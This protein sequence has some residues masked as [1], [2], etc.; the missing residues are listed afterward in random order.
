MILIKIFVINA[1]SSSLKYQLF[2]MPSEKVLAKGVVERIGESDNVFK[3]QGNKTEAVETTNNVEN[4][5][6]A[7]EL[8]IN[9]LLKSKIIGNIDEIKGIGHRIVHGGQHFSGATLI[10]DDVIKKIESLTDLAPI[11]NSANLLGVLCCKKVFGKRV[12]QVAVFDTSFYSDMPEKAYIYG[13][14]YEYYGKYGVRKYGFHGTSHRYVSQKYCEFMQKNIKSAKIISCHLGN[15]SSITAINGG[16]AID[17]T[18]GFTPL[19]GLIMGTRSGSIDPSIINFIAEKESLSFSEINNLLNKKS[20]FLGIAGENDNRIITKKMLN[21]NKNARLAYEI[22]NYQIVK[23][24]GSYIAVMNG[25][26]GIIFTGGIGENDALRRKTVCES[27]LF[28][29]V[30]I[31]DKTNEECIFG[32]ITKISDRN[33]KVNVLVIPTNEELAIAKEVCA[34]CKFEIKF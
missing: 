17:T 34:L 4:H 22:L 8:V 7:F 19:D 10:D 24:I 18:M 9:F 13:I 14:P 31:N 23:Q 26:D 25:C 12:P 15:G 27:L 30:S 20:G 28:F 3:C 1:G 21:G 2:E 16:K 29:G 32:K 33:S 11:H 6:K 5:E